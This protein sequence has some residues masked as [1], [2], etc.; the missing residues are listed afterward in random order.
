MAKATLPTDV[1][2]QYL[3]Q[4][5]RDASQAWMDRNGSPRA[6]KE[7]V[8][9]ALNGQR[10]R[11]LY[12]MLGMKKGSWGDIE[13]T[14]HSAIGKLLNDGMKG[15]IS[16][17][18]GEIIGNPALAINDDDR[19]KLL[20][21]VKDRYLR[22]AEDAIYKEVD[23]RARE[24]VHEIISAISQSFKHL[25]LIDPGEDAKKFAASREF[26]GEPLL[27][28]INVMAIVRVYDGDKISE[29]VDNPEIDNVWFL[30][31]VYT[32]YCP[33]DLIKEKSKS[34][35]GKQDLPSRIASIIITN[36]IT[37]SPVSLDY[38][39]SGQSVDLRYS[40]VV[41]EFNSPTERVFNAMGPADL[42]M[43]KAAVQKYVTD[44][45]DKKEVKTA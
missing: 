18:V 24:D 20:A 11:I 35:S 2:P 27:D 1:T 32:R 39:R 3:L 19:T 40:R 7:F 30:V 31:R 17:L 26:A 12:G 28:E 23:T 25:M 14:D 13:I 44:K 21:K 5:V 8:S 29:I 45:N 43:I 16:E 4:L 42:A 36:G 34:E 22:A 33:L 37:W 9:G 6:I 10:E 41:T 38:R 15:P